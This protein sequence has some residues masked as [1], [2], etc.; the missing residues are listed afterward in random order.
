MGDFNQD[1]CS[2]DEFSPQNQLVIKTELPDIVEPCSSAL[3]NSND[4]CE[5]PKYCVICGDETKCYHYDVASCNGCKTFFRRSIILNKT[6]KCKRSGNCNLKEGTRCRSCRF[7]KC[8]LSGMNLNAIK[9]PD[10]V[11]VQQVSIDLAKRKRE[12]LGETSTEIM[13]KTSPK[14][15]QNTYCQEIDSLLYLEW[16]T[17]RLRE[18]SYNPT[19]LFNDIYEVLKLPSALAK[20][21]SYEK[22]PEWPFD[23][24]KIIAEMNEKMRFGNHPPP[25]SP[26]ELDPA[27][28]NWIMKDIILAIET[29]KTLPVYQKLDDKD[30]VLLLEQVS[31]VNSIVMSCYYSYENKS[32]TVIHPNGIIPFKMVLNNPFGKL[33]RKLDY[34]TLCRSVEP[35][36]R[37]GFNLTEYVLLK[38]IIYC[39]SAIPNISDNGRKLLEK[40]YEE[41]AQ[42]LL[43]YLQSQYGE[44]KGAQRYM[45][46]ISL[47]ETYFYFAKCKKQVHLLKDLEHKKW[48]DENRRPPPPIPKFLKYILLK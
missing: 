47:V 46:V 3:S 41:Y 22:P 24:E 45:E 43:R 33:P 2:L 39:Y 31:V 30:K 38:A 16:K 1:S 29:A 40:Q 19:H 20:A 25:P 37:I 10:S 23:M 18:S 48:T 44:A 14:F 6:Y 17:R 13:P 15:I 7:D 9:F 42:T 35:F 4:I 26:P 5:K 11:N 27:K 34:E 12:I 32:D 28:R 21:D 36:R 8:V